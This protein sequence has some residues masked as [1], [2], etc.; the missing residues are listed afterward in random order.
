MHRHAAA[1][2]STTAAS[3]SLARELHVETLLSESLAASAEAANLR[4]LYSTQRNLYQVVINELT[5][6]LEEGQ[7]LKITYPRFNLDNGVSFILVKFI[8]NIRTN[9]VTMTLWG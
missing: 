2:S 7:F 6:D 4:S 3:H 8:E 5:H 1:D 9:T